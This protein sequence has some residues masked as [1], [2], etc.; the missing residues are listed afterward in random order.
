VVAIEF[1]PLH[2]VSHVNRGEWSF[3]GAGTSVSGEMADIPW[4]AAH[5]WQRQALGGGGCKR[6]VEG[7]AALPAESRSN[8]VK[9]F[10]IRPI[11]M[12]AL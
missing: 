6:S 8:N 2:S 11:T 12:G 3:D 4:Q 9:A 1:V 7:K 5:R 10:Q